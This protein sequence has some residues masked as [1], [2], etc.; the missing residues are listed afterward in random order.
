MRKQYDE[1][2]KK[3]ERD[4]AALFHVTAQTVHS[5]RR[6]FAENGMAVALS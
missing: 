6:A 1:E 4:I 5:I 3:S 2:F